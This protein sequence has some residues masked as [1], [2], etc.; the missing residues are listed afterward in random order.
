[1]IESKYAI[2]YVNKCAAYKES[3]IV[4]FNESSKTVFETVLYNLNIFILVLQA[5]ILRNFETQIKKYIY[6]ISFKSKNRIR[7]F[8]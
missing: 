5:N 3:M 1:M 2:H 6:I 4:N 7:L 8:I